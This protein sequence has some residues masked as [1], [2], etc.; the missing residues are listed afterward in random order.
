MIKHTVSIKHYLLLLFALNV[1]IA[2][3]EYLKKK[4]VMRFLWY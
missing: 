2:T 4:E 3:I 1:V